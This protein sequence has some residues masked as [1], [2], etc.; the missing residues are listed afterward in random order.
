EP[1]IDT[2]RLINLIQTQAK[3]YKFDGVDKLR[4]IQPFENTEQKLEFIHSLMDMLSL[5][6]ES[7]T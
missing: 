4:F 7:K 3:R 2:G 1:H 6:A 5:G